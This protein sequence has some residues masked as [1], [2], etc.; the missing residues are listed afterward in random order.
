[1]N[2][3]PE[4]L[5]TLRER[6]G[7]TQDKLANE[8][9]V[10]KRQII[11]IENSKSSDNVRQNT[12][13]RLAHALKVEQMVLTG[14]KPLDPEQQL[15]LPD[16]QLSSRISSQVQLAYDLVKHRYGPSH[17]DLINLA[18]LLFVLLAEGSLAWRRQCLDGVEEAMERLRAVSKERK[19]LYFTHQQT[20]IELGLCAEEESIDA[21]DLRGDTLRN[22]DDT[23]LDFAGE[24][25][26]EVTPFADYLCKFSEELGISGVVDFGYGV[27]DDP[28]GT[29]PYQICRKELNEITSSSKY[30]RWALEHGDVRLSDIPKELMAEQAR[31]RRIEWL[32]SKLSDKTRKAME[33]HERLKNLFAKFLKGDVQ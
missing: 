21:A 12:V 33:E 6:K 20:N 22:R 23:T 26:Y 5:K 19:H 14:N 32:E 11:R 30:A 15:L 16:V 8:S 7:W 18:P 28:W 3:S 10:S 25:L 27:S 24:D 13:K 17:K 29:E 9:K 4:R 1:M 2:I 31:D